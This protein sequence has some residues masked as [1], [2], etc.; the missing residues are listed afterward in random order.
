MNVRDRFDR[1]PYLPGFNTTGKNGRKR[2]NEL[3]DLPECV[4]K[5]IEKISFADYKKQLKER[6]PGDG[7]LNPQLVKSGRLASRDSLLRPQKRIRRSKSGSRDNLWGGQTQIRGDDGEPDPIIP[8]TQTQRVSSNGTSGLGGVCTRERVRQPTKRITGPRLRFTSTSPRPDVRLGNAQLRF[9]S[10]APPPPR[11]QPTSSIVRDTYDTSDVMPPRPA[12]E[13]SGLAQPKVGQG[14]INRFRHN[15]SHS[16]IENGGGDLD[17]TTEERLEPPAHERSGGKHG[18]VRKVPGFW[19]PPTAQQDEWVLRGSPLANHDVLN[20]TPFSPTTNLPGPALKDGP[21][22]GKQGPTPLFLSHDEVLATSLS[23]CQTNQ[24]STA[25]LDQ[26]SN[27]M[28]GA[29]LCNDLLHRVALKELPILPHAKSSREAKRD[30]MAKRVAQKTIKGSADARPSL[31]FTTQAMA[32]GSSGDDAV[33]GFAYEPGPSQMRRREQFGLLLASEK[34][35]QG[36]SS[37]TKSAADASKR[38]GEYSTQTAWSCA[39]ARRNHTDASDTEPPIQ[40]HQVFCP[41]HGSRTAGEPASTQKGRSRQVH[42]QDW[43]DSI[44]DSQRLPT[45]QAREKSRLSVSHTLGSPCTSLGDRQLKVI[46]GED[47]SDLNESGH[48]WPAIAETMH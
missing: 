21:G 37:Q 16:P 36:A 1:L 8:P 33:E 13:I 12:E 5:P 14:V 44:S 41:K 29:E 11:G 23:Q 28:S 26:P 24:A 17:Q 40:H 18:F 35:A 47:G 42:R 39:E 9:T 34:A 3:N 2:K 30:E 45:P 4:L 43:Q 6:V 15:Q 20:P 38:Q 27:R 32:G 10:R 19:A 31:G 46:D 7:F 25:N 48:Q 22:E